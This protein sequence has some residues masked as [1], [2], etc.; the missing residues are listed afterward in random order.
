MPCPNGHT[1]LREAARRRFVRQYVACLPLV[2][3]RN[4]SVQMK[5]PCN[6][7]PVGSLFRNFAVRIMPFPMA[8]AD[9]IEHRWRQQT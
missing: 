9:S 2:E 6:F 4:I 5:F 1:G 3:R 7:L 8:C